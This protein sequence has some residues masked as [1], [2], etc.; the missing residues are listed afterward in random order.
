MEKRIGFL[1]SEKSLVEWQSI[2]DEICRE[3]GGVVEEFYSTVT[4]ELLH[5]LQW[6]GAENFSKFVLIQSSDKT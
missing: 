1:L 5:N 2:L 3:S 6:E 4:F